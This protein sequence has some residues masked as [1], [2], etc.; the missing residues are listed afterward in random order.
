MVCLVVDPLEAAVVREIYEAYVER[1]RGIGGI[2][3]D[4]N[5]RAVPA[6][7][8]DRRQGRAAWGKGTVWAILRN[9]IY[10]GTLIY[11]KAQY[12]EV[13]KK[14][15]KR[16]RPE[17]EWV[18]AEGVAPTLVSDGLWRAAQAKHGTRRFGVGRPWHRPYLLSGLI[19][20][21]HCGKH[22][23]AHKQAR[24]PGGRLL[25]VYRRS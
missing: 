25:C 6:P 19:V 12:S 5:A 17:S 22:F 3:Q 4:L 9:P 8:S 20:C 10:R 24:G 1:Q 13:G 11:G 7:A 23:Q 14:H 15:G 18:T 21:G 16:R 2:V